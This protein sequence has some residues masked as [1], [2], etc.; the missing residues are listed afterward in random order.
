[1]VKSHLMSSSNYY[2]Y[3]SSDLP[4]WFFSFITPSIIFFNKLSYKRMWAISCTLLRR[5]PFR[6]HFSSPSL[7]NTCSFIF[8][9]NF[10]FQER[11]SL[12]ISCTHRSLRSVRITNLILESL[13]DILERSEPDSPDESIPLN[14][15]PSIE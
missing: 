5:I 6:T 9:R 12:W 3:S 7:L 11:A 15:R 8:R 13:Q 2:M 10:L 4:R 1:M 14:F